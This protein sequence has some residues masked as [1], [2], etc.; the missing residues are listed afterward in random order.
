[1]TR[2]CAQSRGLRALAL[3]GT[4][5]A[6][7]VAM[8]AF[9]KDEAPMFPVSG[10][11]ADGKITFTLP[12]PDSDGLSGCYIYAA[13]LRTGLG[14]PNIVLDRGMAVYQGAAREL[15]DDEAALS[16]HLAVER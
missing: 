13:S 2:Y 9:A 1:M 11:A 15:L 3:A 6:C 5:S 7:L 16:R 8:P 10:S 14:S 12:V 4:A